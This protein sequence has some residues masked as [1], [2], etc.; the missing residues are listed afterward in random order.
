VTVVSDHRAGG[1][2]VEPDGSFRFTGLPPGTYE[3]SAE[4][5]ES[6]ARIEPT[7]YALRVGESL[8]DIALVLPRGATVTGT[9]VDQDG[10]GI[11]GAVISAVGQETRGARTL[12]SGAFALDGL[13][14]GTYAFKAALEEGGVLTTPDGAN[15][16]LA[17]HEVLAA[18]SPVT[19]EL[20]AER[21]K[22]TITGE[23]IDDDGPV[24]DAYVVAHRESASGGALL[25]VSQIWDRQPKLTEPDGSFTLSALPEGAYT[26]RAFRRDGTEGYAEHVQTGTS[27]TITFEP[28][29]RLSGTAKRGDGD[30]LEEFTILM[31][32]RSGG[33]RNETFM[34]R[35][36]ARAGQFSIEGLRPGRWTVVLRAGGRESS[37]EVKLEPGED[38]L[39]YELVLLA[40]VELTGKVVDVVTGE[41][42]ANIFVQAGMIG[43]TT[44]ADGRF[45]L[46]D[47]APG[48]VTV[49]AW[50]RSWVDEG[51]TMPGAFTVTVPEAGG[52][53]GE[54]PVVARALKAG[55]NPGDFGIALEQGMQS[56]CTI[57]AVRPGSPAAEAGVPAGCLITQMNGRA[58]EGNATLVRG[59]LHVP[60]GTT[61][62]LSCD[63]ETEVYSITAG[64]PR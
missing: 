47:V 62:R 59:F 52:D 24:G 60:E 64:P 14:D 34:A 58:I 41:G 54:L 7:Q 13:A 20:R 28:T 21:A 39:G 16:V 50:A 32:D 6:P 42:V 55:Q 63:G 35:A 53:L 29:A 43:D 5:G 48:K 38:K 23:V 33:Y 44:D 56:S 26:L 61:V 37:G 11:E 2:R 8:I 3:L 1:R 57:A 9:L 18:G 46:T 17:T 22:A 19:I 30:P 49:T 51:E 36:G 10:D 25:A 40:G 31:R 15:D 4:T 27:T 12:S 45:T